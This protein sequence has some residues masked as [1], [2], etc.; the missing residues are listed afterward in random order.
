MMSLPLYRIFFE[1]KMLKRKPLLAKGRFVKGGR[2][3]CFG[4]SLAELLVIFAVIGIIAAMTVPTLMAKYQ[5]HVMLVS[6]KKFYSQMNT[7]LKTY[8]ASEGCST[9]DCTSLYSNNTGCI[10]SSEP[11][12]N[13]IKKAEKTF[14]QYIYFKKIPYNSKV[15]YYE[16]DG[17]EVAYGERNFNYYLGY[18]FQLDGGRIMMLANMCGTSISAGNAYACEQSAVKGVKRCN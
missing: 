1:M 7:V 2:K 16:F 8:M 10:S 3:S 4:F 14:S 18:F 9:L 6:L 15:K 5:K 13:Y 12:K 17:T 11:E